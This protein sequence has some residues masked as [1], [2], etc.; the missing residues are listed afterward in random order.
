MPVALVWEK[1]RGLGVCLFLRGVE[2]FPDESSKERERLEE[3]LREEEA[4][5]FGEK[6]LAFEDK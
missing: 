5:P 6:G 3:T 1:W 4:L 2:R